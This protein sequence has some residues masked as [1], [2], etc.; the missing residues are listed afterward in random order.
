MR[1]F[2]LVILISSA[3]FAG[4]E[5]QNSGNSTAHIEGI[6]LDGTTD[7]PLPGAAVGGVISGSDGKFA[8]DLPIPPSC[9]SVGGRCRT[10]LPTLSV[11]KPGFLPGRPEGR[12]FPGTPGI[13]LS[14][15]AGDRLEGL[16]VR[17]FPPGTITGRIFDSRGQPAQ[18]VELYPFRYFYNEAGTRTRQL[19]GTLGLPAKTNDQG[20]FRILNL[21][22][23]DYYFEIHP[24]PLEAG[25]NEFLASIFYPGSNDPS[26]SEAVRVERGTE[27]RVKDIV[28]AP[29]TGGILR[30]RV[31][32][33]AGEGLRG[34]TLVRVER[35]NDWMIPIR[36][37]TVQRGAFD[38]ILEIGRLAPGDYDIRAMHNPGTNQA[39]VPITMGTGDILVDLPVRKTLDGSITGR[40]WITS[41]GGE[42]P[43]A[44]VSLGLFEIF[45]ST[46]QQ[47]QGGGATLPPLT[48]I[49]DGTF[50]ARSISGG[51]I[52][53]ARSSPVFRVRVVAVPQGT[54][55]TSISDGHRDVMQE[56]LF[57]SPETATNIIVRLA[58]GTG[59]IEG[60]VVDSTGE[61]VPFALAALLPDNPA[62][63]SQMMTT[64]SDFKGT[65]RL[66][67]GPGS[68]HLYVWRELP[69][70]AYLN[71]EFMEKYR[72]RGTPVRVE[73]NRRVALNITILED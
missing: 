62:Q 20:E 18:G 26:Q 7:K 32:N 28:L 3:V 16:T 58:P 10:G 46:I 13:P 69:G 67:G 65:Y 50:P 42:Q 45:Q 55:V 44:G 27:T 51:P 35:Q 38:A 23:G 12:K 9:P 6:V 61:R 36:N 49:D 33:E 54:Y 64:I 19:F 52:R 17:L 68:Y 24:K 25:P 53:H 30:V 37:V 2:P 57:V 59:I 8:V 73:P 56:G 60:A 48:S 63:R 1:S 40:A 43:L 41:A 15:A 22:A 72:N 47:A 4:I 14:I 31:I 71:D 39:I 34:T 21:D 11:T 66:E 29:V 70:A 5:I